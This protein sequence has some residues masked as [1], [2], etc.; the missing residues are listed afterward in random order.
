MRRRLGLLLTASMAV[1]SV[2][3]ATPDVLFWKA[4]C[5]SGAVHACASIMI[6]T[7]H[8]GPQGNV[9]QVWIR[10]LQGFDP[11][12]NTGGSIF[13]QFSLGLPNS[14]FLID[15]G[16]SIPR[17]GTHGPVGGLGPQEIGEGYSLT[18]SAYFY[19]QDWAAGFPGDGVQ[20]CNAGPQRAL[21]NGIDVGTIQ[22]CAALGFTGWATLS[23]VNSIFDFGNTDYTYNWD[24]TG[25]SFSLSGFTHDGQ[26]FSIDFPA[27]AAV[28]TPEPSSIALLAAGLAMIGASAWRRGR[29]Q[30][31]AR[32]VG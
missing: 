15:A 31:G 7:V 30:K 25:A 10:N 23:T 1:P 24:T 5:S 28:V 22:T 20:G 32:M 4:L 14:L 27:S 11:R 21:W 12:D 26:G 19:F 9:A 8:Q 18:N 17:L 3:H 6:Q 29:R 16:G 13:N 2:A